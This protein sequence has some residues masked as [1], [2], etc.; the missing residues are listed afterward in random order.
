M[1]S[2][3]GSLPGG[4]CCSA[5]GKPFRQIAGKDQVVSGQELVL[6]NGVIAATNKL[7]AMLASLGY[8]FFFLGRVTGAAWLRKV[9][10]HRM[11]GLYSLINAALCLL[12][13]AF[14]GAGF[15]QAL[16]LFAVLQI[17]V[18]LMRRESILARL[19]LAD[20]D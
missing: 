8:V 6:K 2:L 15:S 5:A 9:S 13:M 14:A 18:M 10:A 1:T 16:V 7:A 4:S 11:L 17:P 19:F 20:A 3:S 12:V